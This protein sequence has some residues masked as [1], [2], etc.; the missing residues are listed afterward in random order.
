VREDIPVGVYD[1]IADF[2]QSRGGNTATILPN[3]SYVARRYGRTILLRANIMRDP[4]IF[5]STSGTLAAAIGEQ[6]AKEL[7]PDGNFY[8]T[9]W[10]EVGHYLGVDRTRDGRE[11]DE[12]LQD[13]ANAMEEMKA[14]LVSLFVAEA[15]HK[16][17]YYSDAQLRSVYAGGILR[18]L[19]NNRPRRDQPYNT[20]QLMQ[21]NFFLENGLLTFDPAT[22]L[23]HVHYE[24]YHDV[25]GK[26]LEKTLAVQFEGDK[27]ASDRYID[28]Y[29]KWDD[30]LHGV[31]A[32]NIRT[33]QRYR[34][35]VFKYAALGE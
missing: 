32:A 34:F 25:V 23:M 27:A 13:N 14:D 8:R 15:L 3:E 7:T 33:Q 4:N 9:L 22:K 1:V 35:R 28:Q 26:M 18:V 10:H 20:M 21:W 17:G 29:T 2:G 24:K 6:Q 16:Q 19:Q 12:A 5:E 31:I 11:L 30:N